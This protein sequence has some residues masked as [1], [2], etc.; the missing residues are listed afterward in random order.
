MKVIIP[1]AV[2]SVFSTFAR[3]STATWFDSNKTLTTALV[4]GIRGN[5]NPETSVYEGV[6][7]EPSRTNS[8]W[9][10]A[11]PT[12][13][14]TITVVK[15]APYVLSFYGIGT[16]TMDVGATGSLTGVN[17]YPGKRVS[18]KVVPSGN[19]IRFTFTSSP[20]CVQFEEGYAATSYIPTT[21][22]SVTRAADIVTVGQYYTTFTDS[23]PAYNALTAY[24]IGDVVQYNARKYSSKTAA[25]T[26]NTPSTSTANWTDIGATNEWAMHDRTSGGQ[27]SGTGYRV[28]AFR[29]PSAVD[30]VALVNIEATAVTVVVSTG[31]GEVHS[32]TKVGTAL[33]A[34]AFTGFTAGEYVTVSIY[35]GGAL[36]KLGECIAGT[37]FEVGDTEFPLDITMVDYSRKETDPDFG[38]VTFV[39]RDYASLIDAT[40]EVAKVRHGLVT[41]TLT[42]L[43]AKPTAYIFS[44]DTDYGDDVIHYAYIMSMR[45]SIARPTLS[46]LSIELGS[47]V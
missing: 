18:L 44:D 29:A 43:R 19:Q 46:I 24:A 31:H 2:P 30:A 23:T 27:S 7:I 21:T 8:I 20:R 17:A 36:A 28:F 41:K 12:G 13:Q 37:L 33:T 26:G 35:N 38:T 39:E 34:V 10:S 4:D 47:L 9:P 14:Q 15:D 42:G 1:V 32:Q 40:V 16:I 5:W 6:T 3:A 25:N 45:R 22:A 11:A